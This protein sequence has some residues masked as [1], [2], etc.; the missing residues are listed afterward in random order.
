MSQ[1]ARNISIIGSGPSGL[2]TAYHLVKKANTIKV[3]INIKIWEK[4]PVPFGL[5][6]YGVAPDHPEV[7][8][9]EDTFTT[10]FREYEEL[11]A[12]FCKSLQFI[13]NTIV[14]QPS[15]SSATNPFENHVALKSLMQTEDV[16]VLSYGCNGDRRLN[17]PHEEECSSVFTSRQFVNWYNGQFDVALSDKFMK[18]DWSKVR[19]VGIIGNGNVALDVARLLISNQVKEL[20][21][22]SDISTVALEQLN[23]AP[24]ESVKI[25]GRRDFSHSK[26]TNKEYRE[27][28][29]LEKYGIF[30][31]IISTEFDTLVKDIKAP[32]NDRVMMR[33]LEMSKEYLLPFDQR[34][35]KNY[36]K[37]RPPI[38]R[39]ESKK[40]WEF[41][42]LLSPVGINMHP[43]TKD[44]KSVTFAQNVMQKD[45]SLVQS[46]STVTTDFDLLITSLGY[47]GEPL[48][49]FG[50]LGIQ[51]DRSHVKNI[52]GRV[53]S[54]SD[55]PIPGLYTSGWINNG[56]QGVIANTMQGAFQVADRILEDM[57]AKPIHKKSTSNA[58]LNTQLPNQTTWADWEE[59]NKK[60]LQKGK[61]QGKNRSKYITVDSVMNV[62]KTN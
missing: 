1:V 4:N 14:G 24:I 20:W 32:S 12:G 42:Y 40:H 56:G 47:K 28:W 36:K 18:F 26:F 60:E 11:S 10:M 48:E 37:V 22:V 59:I 5:S 19:K 27:L 43:G 25:I 49:E 61:A 30:G 54:N 52:D 57:A 34:S 9:C 13:G 35:K 50:E 29:E 3:P 41:D 45:G 33:R 21:G 58:E 44:L 16:V 23:K 6:R 38:E 17:I 46:D 2:Y 7:K 31:N 53:L 39:A 15:M 51:F 55:V 8:N 62:L